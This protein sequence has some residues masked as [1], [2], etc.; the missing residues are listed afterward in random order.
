MRA[1]Q[2]RRARRSGELLV[3]REALPAPV[4]RR[5]QAANLRADARAVLLLPLPHARHERLPPQPLTPQALR[6]QHAL[7]YKLRR[8]ALRARAAGR[9]CFGQPVPVSS[10]GWRARRARSHRVV[11]TGHPQRSLALHTRIAYHEVLRSAGRARRERTRG[12]SG[13]RSA[14]AGRT[15]L[16]GTAARR[17]CSVTNMAWPMCSAPVTFGGGMEMTNGSPSSRGAKYPADSHLCA[18]RRGGGGDDPAG[19]QPVR[20]SSATA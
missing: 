16:V 11:G 9:R 4:A 15:G 10:S 17:A 2:Y 7:H 5:A 20:R 1:L 6:R 8:D 19:W 14:P 13:A 12:R 3:Q 18:D